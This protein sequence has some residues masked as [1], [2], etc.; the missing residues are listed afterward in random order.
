MEKS[1]K[2]CILV[3]D[4]EEDVLEY[5]DHILT[6]LD[7]EVIT[8]NNGKD[9]LALAKEHKPDLILLDIVMP[10]MMGCEVA[11]SL[12]ADPELSFVPIVFLS[13]LNTSNDQGII[14]GKKG[15]YHLLAKPISAQD[16]INLVKE[17]IP[18]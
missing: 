8:S 12:S 10:G 18:Q 5:L 6:R 16:I 11:D 15:D 9:A 1:N 2:R 4:D 7:Y 13:G 17:I 3:V 14:K